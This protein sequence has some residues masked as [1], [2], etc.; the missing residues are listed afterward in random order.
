MTVLPLAVALP[1]TSRH[2]PD[3]TLRIVPSVLRFHCWLAPPLQS[4]SCALAPAVALVGES[5]HLPRDCRV[6]P[7]RAQRWFAAPLQSQMIGW[8]PLAVLPL[9]TSR[10]RPEAALTSAVP[11]PV[12]A[13]S[14]MVPGTERSA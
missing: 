9:G 7:L 2:S 11:V 14:P 12:P 6:W 8:T 4:H 5:R 13:G 1:L 10:Q 3:C